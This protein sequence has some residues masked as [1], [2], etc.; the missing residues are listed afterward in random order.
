ME[1]LRMKGLSILAIVLT[2]ARYTDDH[3]YNGQYFTA[4]SQM[5]SQVMHHAR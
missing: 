1:R 4:F 5:L 2:L 3:V